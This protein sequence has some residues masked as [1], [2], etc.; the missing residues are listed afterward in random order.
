[1]MDLAGAIT[2]KDSTVKCVPYT[3]KTIN[4][5]GIAV[6]ETQYINHKDIDN[7][8]SCVWGSSTF[9]D[10]DGNKNCPQSNTTASNWNEI[11]VPHILKIQNF[12]SKIE[13]SEVKE[14][15][16]RSM[17]ETINYLNMQEVPYN[18]PDRTIPKTKETIS[19]SNEVDKLIFGLYNIRRDYENNML[20]YF[21]DIANKLEKMI[22][23]NYSEYY[24]LLESLRT[25]KISKNSQVKDGFTNLSKND[26]LKP[27]FTKNNGINVHLSKEPL[28]NMYIFGIGLFSLYMIKRLID[29]QG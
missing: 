7:Y 12:N 2:A 15:D 4:N 17:F 5:D 22:N 3:A 6:M 23:I 10:G 24:D 20:Y 27:F 25:H 13:S 19:L 18:E 16:F 21:H 11:L 9:N 29:K 28:D 14:D 26:G 8:N 1:M